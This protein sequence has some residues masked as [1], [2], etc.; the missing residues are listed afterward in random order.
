MSVLREGLG[1]DLK[2]PVETR[3][4]KKCGRGPRSQV[5]EGNRSQ[6]SGTSVN[7]LGGPGAAVLRAAG[8]ACGHWDLHQ[9]PH[10]AQTLLYQSSFQGLGPSTDSHNANNNKKPPKPC[11]YYVSGLGRGKK[12]PHTYT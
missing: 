8:D 1:E 6:G 7:C 9:C 10:Y 3:L 11:C 5:L 12:L 4:W 2:P